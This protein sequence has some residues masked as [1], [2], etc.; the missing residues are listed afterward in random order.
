MDRQ[1]LRDWVHR[2]NAEGLAG[3]FDR[4]LPGRAPMLDAEQMG[5]LA[6]IV[7]KGL[8]P[9]TDGVVRWRR[10]DLCRVVERRFEVRL[11]E[12][13]MGAALRRLGFAKLSA[14]P[15]HPQG[16]AQAQKPYKKTS[17]TSRAAL[18]DDAK[19]KPLELWFQML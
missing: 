12:R 18:P 17:P 16:K 1:T 14:R 3:L 9:E 11:A 4:P 7:E 8:D 6:A 13:T 2:Y 15:R 10:I 19:G 5:E